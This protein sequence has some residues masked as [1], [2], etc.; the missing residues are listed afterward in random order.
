MVV[1]VK[2]SEI[3]DHKYTTNALGTLILPENDKSLLAF[4]C[5]A[6]KGETLPTSRKTFDLDGF[7]TTKKGSLVVLLHGLPGADKTYTTGGFKPV[8]LRCY[9]S[10][11]TE[12]VANYNQ[13]Y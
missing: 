7:M 9:S 10:Q 12:C 11:L 6:H 4:L 13:C 1:A 8:T 2:I 5:D 3:T